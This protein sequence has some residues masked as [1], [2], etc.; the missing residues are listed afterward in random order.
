M[1]AW[2]SVALAGEVEAGPIR[3]AEAELHVD[4]RW[5]RPAV[6]AKRNKPAKKARVVEGWAVVRLTGERDAAVDA[7]CD[8]RWAK[9]LCWSGTFA[10]SDG[11]TGL[12]ELGPGEGRTQALWLTY[13]DTGAE[14]EGYVELRGGERFAGWLSLPSDARWDGHWDEALVVEPDAR[15]PATARRSR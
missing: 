8:R 5:T 15:P 3:S 9:E 4:Y 11:G 12:Y 6:P 13:D 14:Y 1:F 10:T 2:I 7:R